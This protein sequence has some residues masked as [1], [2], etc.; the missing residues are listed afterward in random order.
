M[1]LA[2]SGEYI[3]YLAYFLNSFMLKINRAAAMYR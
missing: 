3:C 2:K 1:L